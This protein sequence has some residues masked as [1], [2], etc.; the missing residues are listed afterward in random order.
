MNYFEKSAALN[1]QLGNKDAA[2]IDL[3][4]AYSIA[5]ALGDMDTSVRL[6]SLL[7]ELTNTVQ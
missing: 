5:V 3:E 6:S 2:R 1:L 4:S 7:E